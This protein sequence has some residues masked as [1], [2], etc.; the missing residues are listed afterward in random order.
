MTPRQKA[1]ID[2]HRDVA[3][4]A[5]T[6]PDTVFVIL[7]LE[8]RE[9]YAMAKELSPQSA[10]KRQIIAESGSIPAFT[11]TLPRDQAN[12]LLDHGWPGA[13][14]IPAA[15]PELVPIML[16]SDGRCMCLFTRRP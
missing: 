9:G 12:K 15:G 4:F 6:K 13:K 1:L 14:H 10:E 7:D 5:V 11:L 16:V 8:D 2:Y 3:A